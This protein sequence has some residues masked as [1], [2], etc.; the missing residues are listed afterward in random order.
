MAH[1]TDPF[2]VAAVIQHA[3]ETDTP[4]LRYPV[5]WA[6]PEIIAGRAN[7]SDEDWVS[8]GTI[9]DDQQYIERFREVFGVDIST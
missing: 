3:I 4:V 8:M 5:S 1:A 2:E 6:G 7:L 9:D